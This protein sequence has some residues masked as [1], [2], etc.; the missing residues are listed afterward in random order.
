[1]P[2]TVEHQECAAAWR[3]TFNETRHKLKHLIFLKGIYLQHSKTNA[4]AMMLQGKSD[5]YCNWLSITD[6]SKKK[7]K[8][9][10][11]QCPTSYMF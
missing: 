7:R 10:E 6:W 1:M 5:F 9:Y 4:T 2:P 8:L 11:Y 3:I